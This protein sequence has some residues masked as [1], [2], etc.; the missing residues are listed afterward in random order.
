MTVG[1]PS[2]LG[3]ILFLDD[4]VEGGMP[5]SAP[6]I[7]APG[8]TPPPIE[9]TDGAVRLPGQRRR[10]VAERNHLVLDRE[11]GSWTARRDLEA[12]GPKG[13]LDI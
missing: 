4:L 13:P 10:Y 11:A 9:V 12:G 7:T 5:L 3:P 6:F 1:F 2:P 8:D